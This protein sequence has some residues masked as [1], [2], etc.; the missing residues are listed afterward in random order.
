MKSTLMILAAAI[1]LAACGPAPYM[2]WSKEGGTIEDKG[3]SL[4]DCETRARQVA[5]TFQNLSQVE[6]FAR[7]CMAGHGYSG[8]WVR[9]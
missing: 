3:R 8:H 4:T 1:A 2:E 6:G 7:R 9:P 5:H